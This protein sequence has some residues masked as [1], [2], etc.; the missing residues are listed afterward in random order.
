MKTQKNSYSA[1]KNHEDTLKAF[2]ALVES[3]TTGVIL[4][5]FTGNKVNEE[6]NRRMAPWHAKAVDSLGL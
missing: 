5:G 4:E 6:V 1:Q 2:S 3:V